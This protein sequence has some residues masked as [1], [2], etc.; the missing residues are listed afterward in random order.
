MSTAQNSSTVVW[1]ELHTGGTK[2]QAKP[3]P[4]R[5]L[6]RPRQGN[7]RGAGL[8]KL[9]SSL[10]FLP[11]NVQH[12]VHQSSFPFYDYYCKDKRQR[13]DNNQTVPTAESPLARG[14]GHFDF[15]GT[16]C[17]LKATSICWQ[18]IVSKLYLY[19]YIFPQNFSVS[20]LTM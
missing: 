13:N 5:S 14:P 18:E 9:L 7:A 6:L 11:G 2:I 1:R 8:F 15:D 20:K 17:H 12:Y 4:A 19:C 16:I 3:K 10:L